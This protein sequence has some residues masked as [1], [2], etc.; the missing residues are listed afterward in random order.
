MSLQLTLDCLQLRYASQKKGNRSKSSY[1]LLASSSCVHSVQ[2]KDRKCANI[3]FIFY[4]L[5]SNNFLFEEKKTL[6]HRFLND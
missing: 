2:K 1:K 3:E 6:K 5:M 4:L